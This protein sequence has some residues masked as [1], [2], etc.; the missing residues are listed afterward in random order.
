MGWQDDLMA[1]LTAQDEDPVEDILMSAPGQA[2]IG[3]LTSDPA[4]FIFKTIDAPF[5]NL[6]RGPVGSIVNV[7][8][9]EGLEGIGAEQGQRQWDEGIAAFRQAD[10][11]PLGILK[12][13]A[14]LALNVVADPVTWTG[15]GAVGKG[16]KALQ[17][18]A[19]QAMIRG[20]GGQAR[21][22]RAAATGLQAAQTV[23]DVRGRVFLEGATVGGRRIPGA[24]AGV[25]AVGRAV[26]RVK[27]NALAESQR[28]IAGRRRSELQDLAGAMRVNR[29]SL[30][31][32]PQP[33]KIGDVTTSSTPPVMPNVHP[34]GSA[35]ASIY[36]RG[37]DAWKRIR[38]DMPED[39][40]PEAGMWATPDKVRLTEAHI[41]DIADIGATI[42]QTITD[43]GGIYLSLE[44]AGR[45]MRQ[46]QEE[47]VAKYGA[48]I[49][50]YLPLVHDR[51]RQKLRDLNDVKYDPDLIMPSSRF[52]L[53][54]GWASGGALKTKKLEDINA[55][56]RKGKKTPEEAIA[57][58]R[59]KASRGKG[60]P[61]VVEA[62]ADMGAAFLSLLHQA[63]DE[64]YKQFQPGGAMFPDR[65]T[66]NAK[67]AVHP[68]FFD[69][70]WG[71]TQTFLKVDPN[72]DQ[73]KK[74]LGVTQPFGSTREAWN[75]YMKQ[76][77]GGFTDEELNSLAD[78]A[79]ETTYDNFLNAANEVSGGAQGATKFASS[80]T[81]EGQLDLTKFGGD[82]FQKRGVVGRGP[83]DVGSEYAQ[84]I[85]RAADEE[86]RL[87]FGR[88]HG[89]IKVESLYR[90][91]AR[92]FLGRDITVDD[93][94]EVFPGRS[95]LDSKN[96]GEWLVAKGIEPIRQ[97]NPVG[98]L[99]PNLSRLVDI[100]E[101]G[102][103]L[104]VSPLSRGA[105]DWYRAGAKEIVSIVGAGNYEDA[106]L[107]MDL[108][109]I[110]S[111]ATEVS[112]NALYALRMLAEWKYGKADTMMQQFGIT[113]PQF[114]AI[115]NGKLLS[116]DIKDKDKIEAAYTEYARRRANIGRLPVAV[117]GGGPKTF[118][119]SSSFLVN[120][121]RNM[122]EGATREG[123][124][125]MQGAL[126]A[127]N[128]AL[129][130]FTVDRHANRVEHLA[131][132]V[133]GMESYFV[134]ERGVLA[135]RAAREGEGLSGEAAQ[136]AQWYWS[137]D[138]Q[139][140]ARM[141]RGD[142]DIAFA[143]RN[144][145]EETWDANR[146]RPTKA[147]LTEGGVE[148]D[149][150]DQTWAN[151]VA[152]VSRETG[153]QGD[154][155]V[156]ETYNLVRQEMFYR[157]LGK[158]LKENEKGI[159]DALT[160]AGI[161]PTIRGLQA[162]WAGIVQRG[163]HGIAPD[164]VSLIRGDRPEIPTTPRRYTSE[165]ARFQS[166]L[167]QQLDDLGLPD[168]ELNVVNKIT[169]IVA[170][171][172]GDRARGAYIEADLEDG[173]LRLIGVSLANTTDTPGLS[174]LQQAMG[175]LDH[176]AVHAMK[177][178]KLFK[179]DEWKVLVEAAKKA[180]PQIATSG[181]GASGFENL[182]TMVRSTYRGESEDVIEE[183]LVARLFQ[184]WRTE[185]RLPEWQ[186]METG[187][188]VRTGVVEQYLSRML[189][190][191]VAI[192]RSLWETHPEEVLQ[193]IASGEVGRR[194]GPEWR[195]M[196]LEMRRAQDPVA[197]L[198]RQQAVIMSDLDITNQLSTYQRKIKGPLMDAYA[199]L[200]LEE[201]ANTV[202]MSI[203]DLDL[204][205]W[206]DRMAAKAKGFDPRLTLQ[207]NEL[208][209]TKL[210]DGRTYKEVWDTTRNEANGDMAALK[211]AGV[212]WSPY[213]SKDERIA[214]AGNN[215]DLKKII[216]KWTDEGIDIAHA[217]DGDQVAAQ[218][219]S[220]LADKD[221][222]IN[223]EKAGIYDLFRAAWGEQALLSIKYHSGNFTGGYIQNLLAGKFDWPPL[224]EVFKA[225]K[226]LRGGYDEVT[227]LEA[228]ESLHATKVARY[229]GLD[230]PPNEI[231]RGGVKALTM[232]STGYGPSA[233]GEMVGRATRNPSLGR[234]AGWMFQANNDMGLAIDTGI[235]GSLWEQVFD[236]AMRRMLPAW[237]TEVRRRG[238]GIPNFDLTP[239][240]SYQPDALKAHLVDLGFQDGVAE[241]LMRKFVEI[242]GLGLKEAKKEL[243][244]VQFYGSRTNL[245]EW[246]S[247]VVP[248][249]YWFSRALRFYG[250]EA[251]RHPYLLLNYMRLSDGIDDA[252]NDPGLS[253]RQKG[254]IRL[255][256]T[257]LG[258]SLLMNPDALF[259]VVRV[260]GMDTY[261]REQGGSTWSDPPEGYTPLGGA[262]DWVK[263]RG[264]GI[265]PWIDGTLNL[266]GAYGNDFEPDLLGIRHKAL[267]GAAVNYVRAGLGF[268]PVG[269]PYA[270]A[271]GQA[272]W[273]TS[274]FISSFGPDWLSQPV[275]PRAGN[276]S[277][278]AAL[279]TLI[280]SVIMEN[281][282]GLT[283]G[284]LLAIMVNPDHPEYDR[285]YQ[286]VAQADITQQLLN[287]TLPV[288]WRMR[289]DA[290]DVRR[291]QVEVV[292]EEARKQGVAPFE[293]AATPQSLAFQAKHKALT[294]KE[295]DPAAYTDAKIKHDLARAPDEAKV[296]I[297]AEH[298]YN[299]LGTPE[300]KA[301][302]QTYTDLIN[303]TDERTKG[304]SE[305]GRFEVAN[306][307]LYRTRGAGKAIDEVRALRS[308]FI[309]SHPE[310]AEFKG[311][312]ERMFKLRDSLGGNL[313]EYRRQASAQNPNAARYFSEQWDW[314]TKNLPE[315]E[316]DEQFER[317]TTN[318]NAFLSIT[319]HPQLRSIQG[320]IP[321]V[322]KAD[323]TLPN[324]EAQMAT[325]GGPPS[326][327]WARELAGMSQNAGVQ[328]RWGF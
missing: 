326:Y 249:H 27:P 128:K 110:T 8:Q 285:A 126:E 255:F 75:T 274:S 5:A 203:D 61:Q 23:D 144:A 114:D 296:F 321:G 52:L 169:D 26:T 318:A 119:Y 153:L 79:V 104:F 267:V 37:I 171:A 163:A 312:Q 220:K 250:E 40:A 242:R 208:L 292:A 270:Q 63:D 302:Y 310:F 74:L 68:D 118:N 47:V 215:E 101:R 166:I 22:L 64:V 211:D 93:L 25:R 316:W 102:A 322:P 50:P 319:G 125:A 239:P 294:G 136:A 94:K 205:D 71:D 10:L 19:N 247:K 96:I 238:A 60:S 258:F 172:Q 55:A 69:E 92:D 2:A 304:L 100:A 281:N 156:Q 183:E 286:A 43:Q 78:M 70:I 198:A 120:V 154:E 106:T 146:S 189:N 124:P 36:Q 216:R 133:N 241:H 46:V 235:R 49:Q 175:T 41:D 135:A 300:Q 9:G 88:K 62:A 113:G 223:H 170:M 279:D 210:A 115:R 35:P 129:T 230:G 149:L 254:F 315:D 264:L 139:G 161:E 277:Q 308:A 200:S 207:Q 6:V 29:Q 191:I 11:G 307:Y 253:A 66:G 42:M 30:T 194:T 140:F 306:Q 174:H 58:A 266:M 151:V 38:L 77:F 324:A 84:R 155:A 323:I 282:P 180:R 212:T 217:S 222:G 17:V 280:E 44:R 131:T 148:Q 132:A 221:D 209:A 15:I 298:D 176:E 202:G 45:G 134:R 177:A 188:G 130:V 73:V 95:K 246:I 248:F 7:A 4:N 237:E 244:R 301:I 265:Y 263:Q 1:L 82:Q 28:S 224:V 291:A 80:L 54:H 182:E 34:T 127:F 76:Q 97:E 231:M 39:P 278:E 32:D 81:P 3:A 65:V 314:I 72:T 251:V 181:R 145:I 288:Q 196:G 16:A 320:P 159:R 33:V 31:R 147:A 197:D 305:P 184:Y 14:E 105:A 287:F 325:Q 117:T 206:P 243:D 295:F 108:I 313:A 257:P 227:R 283:N 178:L 245:D 56:V 271:M 111:S 12:T 18:A 193:R 137:R 24:Q 20:A 201:T 122:I 91:Q 327:D 142:S 162:E 107:L 165:Q 240:S 259:G 190:F 233:I 297:M 150:T 299:N 13:P 167:R 53:P 226:G 284:D 59:K 123:G 219:I 256:G 168:V 67:A 185:G 143:L 103:P 85:I 199:R 275:T 160:K 225:F 173:L 89:R 141:M 195:Q 272:R 268:D 187:V 158:S 317:S 293:I 234:K 262:L 21:A 290:T 261:E 273:A 179:D 86:G 98:G 269:A 109:A 192:A 218:R 309:S 204:P 99:L 51:M 90:T 112:D 48:G 87:T 289:H 213:A 228:L 236:D 311:W 229:W 232:G 186:A 138:Q 157:L 121:W 214:A 116:L 276:S 328:T 83:G 152:M 303:G 252:Q 260:F 57:D 164:E